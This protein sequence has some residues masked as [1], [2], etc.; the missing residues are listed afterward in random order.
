M[1]AVVFAVVLVTAG[2]ATGRQADIRRARERAVPEVF[3]LE[4]DLAAGDAATE[5]AGGPAPRP[6]TAPAPV[7]A[8][9]DLL[10]FAV[11]LVH[12]DGS[13]LS[14]PKLTCLAGQRANIQMV[15]QH[16]YIADLDIEPSA[17]GTSLIADPVVEVLGT[18][19]SLDLLGAPP[20]AP[21]G[22]VP[23]ALSLRVSARSG[24]S[25]V[26]PIRV[27]AASPARIE[28]PF[29]DSTEL[30]VGRRL[31]QGVEVRVA[32][33]PGP[34]GPLAVLVTVTAGVLDPADAVLFGEAPSFS[35][36]NDASLAPLLDRAASG[37]PERRLTATAGVSGSSPRALSRIAA[38]SV[39]APGFRIARGFDER[40]LQDYDIRGA[41]PNVAADPVLATHHSGFSVADGGDGGLLAEWSVTPWIL[42]FTTRIDSG[43]GNAVEIEVPTTSTVRRR[44][45][46][47]GGSLSLGRVRSGGEAVLR[48]DVD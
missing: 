4:T 8:G 23:A 31:P 40:Y 19:V 5:P 24:Q 13:V 33:I 36:G 28:A 26:I 2:C 46:A 17:D 29:V 15:Q 16:A 42:P 6:A 35:S 43:P 9:S 3:R 32:E 47:A 11:R 48:V 38:T 14:A 39:L 1:R 37:A 25:R 10:T 20:G 21:G 44:V 34:D 27:A 7:R 18:G 12:P 45:A 30:T 41:V 22:P